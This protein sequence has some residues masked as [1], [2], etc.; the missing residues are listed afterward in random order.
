[1]ID[2]FIICL[3]YLTESKSVSPLIVHVIISKDTGTLIPYTMYMYSN[4]YGIG[5][6]DQVKSGEHCG[7]TLEKVL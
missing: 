7:P 4:T 5:N 6:D 3:Q 2:F 1:M